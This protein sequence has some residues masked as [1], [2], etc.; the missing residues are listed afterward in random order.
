MASTMQKQFTGRH[1]LASILAFFGV[2][3]GVNLTMAYLANSTWSGLV[4]ANGYVASQSFDKDLARSRQQDAL[5]WRVG[6]S[7]GGGRVR[8]T[9]SDAQQK[10]IEGLIITGQLERPTTASQDQMLIFTGTGSGVYSA[11]AKLT[12]GVWEVEVDARSGAAA[13]F[14]KIFRFIVKD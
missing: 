5:G 4:V 1:M 11:P 12:P 10:K 14:H 7:H 2:I 9:F 3:L 8:L 13:D 6:L